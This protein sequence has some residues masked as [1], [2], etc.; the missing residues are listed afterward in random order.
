VGDP[1]T[2]GFFEFNIPKHRNFGK[3]VYLACFKCKYKNGDV[4][5]SHEH[6]SFRWVNGNNY[7]EVD[8]GTDFFRMLEKYFKT[9]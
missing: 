8:D 3:K 6:N 1:F 5:L 2:T 7:K 9:P 4:T